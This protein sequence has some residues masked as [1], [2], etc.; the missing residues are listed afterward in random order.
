MGACFQAVS[1]KTTDVKEAI[2]RCHDYIDECKYDYGH[3]GYTGTFAECPGAVM[4]SMVF[5]NVRDAEDWLDE[6]AEKW[7]PALG[8]TVKVPDEEPFIMFGAVCSS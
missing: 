8:V 3:A 6:N 1:F 4:T 7:E 5:T 2:S